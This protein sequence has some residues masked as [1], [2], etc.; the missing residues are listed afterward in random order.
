MRYCASSPSLVIE[1]LVPPP[2]YAVASLRPTT[3]QPLIVVSPPEEIPTPV[4]PKP[5]PQFGEKDGEGESI[6]TL[7]L[8]EPAQSP[9]PHEFEQAWT[10][11]LPSVSTLAQEEQSA[12]KSTALVPS[13]LSTDLPAM[14]PRTIGKGDSKVEAIESDRPVDEKASDGKTTDGMQDDREG[15]AKPAQPTAAETDPAPR[16]ESDLDQFADAEG[17]SLLGGT[18]ARKGRELK[19][20]RP[21]VDLAFRA[22]FTRLSDGKMFVAFRITTDEKGSPRNVEILHSSGSEDIDDSLRLAVYSSWFGGKMPDTFDFVIG[23]YD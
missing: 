17:I 8:P 10:S 11:R 2:R 16:G 18:K 23:L 1:L 14:S 7:D 3:G 19:F 12:K 5:D 4:E 13:G 21:R 20:A 6:S 22:A 9:K 15:D